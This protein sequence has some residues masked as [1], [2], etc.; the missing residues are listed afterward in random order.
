MQ[1]L[2]SIHHIK[3]GTPGAYYLITSDLN[4]EF[5]YLK[6]AYHLPFTFCD[7]FH[8]FTHQRHFTFFQGKLA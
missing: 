8:D 2:K 6:Q 3:E 7:K 4:P 5:D 1:C